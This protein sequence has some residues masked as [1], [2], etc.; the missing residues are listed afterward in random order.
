VFEGL[1]PRMKKNRVE[2]EIGCARA[3]RISDRRRRNSARRLSRLGDGM[4]KR[5][6]F[7]SPSSVDARSDPD[8]HEE[9]FKSTGGYP[10]HKLAWKGREMRTKVSPCSASGVDIFIAKVERHIRKLGMIVLVHI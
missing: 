5:G 10:G 6:S 1:K 4:I 8:S 9:L 7:I 2:G 3:S